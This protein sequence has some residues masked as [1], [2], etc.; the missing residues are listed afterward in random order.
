[1]KRRFRRRRKIKYTEH[2]RER[3]RAVEKLSS[4]EERS[5]FERDRSRIIHSSAFRRLQGKTQVFAV[6]EGDFFRTRLT[7]SLEVAQIAKGLA[8]RLGADPDLV[9]SI[10]LIH[11]IGHPPFGHSGEDEL[12]R[13]MMPYGGFEANAQNVRVLTE[14]ETKSGRF[15]GLNLTRATIDGQLKYKNLFCR[16]DGLSREERQKLKFVYRED[17]AIVEWA[18]K[19]ARTCI[20]GNKREWKSFECEI[21]DWADDIAYA[22]HDLE[23]GIH[24]GQI[25]GDTLQEES[26]SREVVKK[27]GEK[28]EQSAKDVDNV[29]DSLVNELIAGYPAFQPYGPRNSLMQRK[30]DRKALTS[31]LI[32][33]FIKCSDRVKRG[34][35]STPLVSQRYL[36]AVHIPIRH[37]V[38]VDLIKGLI[39]KYVI[40]SPQVRT[41]EE[42][43]R[44]IV[45][46]LFLKFTRDD[47]A[48]HL[49]PNDWKEYWCKAES[50]ADKAR[51]VS[52]YISGMTDSYAQKT[53]ARLFLPNQGS[54]YDLL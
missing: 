15:K 12:K 37:R 40:E 8:L 25:T 30:S 28:Y 29:W 51:V 48:Q 47:N 6:G 21:M 54:V 43:A 53:Y 33:R 18:S 13:L 31:Y 39:M 32:G 36:Y 50:K 41:L 4:D 44:N 11:D 42:K 22:V 10:S 24:G 35:L 9:E 17:N 1:M 16:R 49:L 52:D 19:E 23:D 45:R 14:L 27:V 2:D 34:H 3:Y 7:H 26:D 5:E 38:E 46:C 20:E